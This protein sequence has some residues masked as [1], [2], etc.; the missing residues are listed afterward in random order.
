MAIDY[1]L[2]ESFYRSDEL[3]SISIVCY[4]GKTIF[5]SIVNPFDPKCLEEIISKI[6][7]ML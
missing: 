5:N 2:I 7:D 3:V 1:E 6:E 4:C